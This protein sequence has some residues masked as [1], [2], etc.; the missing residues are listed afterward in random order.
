MSSAADVLRAAMRT[1]PTGV[2]VVTTL[3]E[4]VPH[5]FTANAFT[6][7]S[8]DPPSVLLCVNR[9][10][11]SHGLISR[12]GIFCVNILRYEQRTAADHFARSGDDT[13]FHGVP[14]TPAPSGAPAIDGSLS[15]LDCEVT[16]EHSVATHTIF[17]GAVRHG[18]AATGRPLGYLNGGF[19]D[20]GADAGD[21]HA[22][23]T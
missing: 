23:A 8:L 16:E 3:L 7:V 17:V 10:A 20:F 15:W 13:Q 19:Y 18:R 5:G 22:V 14:W 6:S 1:F 21:P 2:T 4:A 12:A 11:R 9:N